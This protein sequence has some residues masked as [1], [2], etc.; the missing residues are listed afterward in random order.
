M[1]K[2][3]VSKKCKIRKKMYFKHFKQMYMKHSNSGGRCRVSGCF[4]EIRNFYDLHNHYNC[5]GIGDHGIGLLLYAHEL[6]K[7]RGGGVEQVNGGLAPNIPG[8]QQTFLFGFIHVQ[9]LELCMAWHHDHHGHYTYKHYQESD[10]SYLV[11]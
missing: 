8:Q 4:K 2:A 1:T 9:L 7:L 5:I 10:V 6:K 3:V 11:I